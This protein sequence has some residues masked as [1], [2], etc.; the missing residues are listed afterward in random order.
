MRLLLKYLLG[1]FGFISLLLYFFLNSNFSNHYLS[2]Y[3]SEKSKNK[4]TVVSWRIK[5]YPKLN[6]KVKI[7]GTADLLLEGRADLDTLD[8]NYTLTGDSFSYGKTFLDASIDFRGN[9]HGTYNVLMLEGEGNVSNHQE[10]LLGKLTLK[11]ASFD[12]SKEAFLG[13]YLLD[14]QE[15]AHLEPYLH[16][17]YK[18]ALLTTGIVEYRDKNVTLRGETDSFK[19]HLYY[20]YQ[21][22]SIDLT[23]KGVSL[24]K[25][26]EQ[27]RYKALVEA[28]VFGTVR[29]DPIQK[30]AHIDTQL[31]GAHFQKN[32]ITDAIQKQTGIN[33]LSHRY[34][35]SSLKGVYQES[36]LS[37]T[38]K[39]D[40]GQEHLYLK[41]TTIEGQS[42]KLNAKFELKM[43]GQELYGRL[44]GTI[45]KP[46]VSLDISKSLKYQVDRHLGKFL[47]PTQKE[48]LK[49]SLG[50]M[51]KQLKDINMD[52]VKKKA[53][54]LLKNLF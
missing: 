35:Q 3:L 54:N 24:V 21:P 25:L 47:N 27:Y 42:K 36:K 1:F 52:Q 26:L 13:H 15:L 51:K 7:N 23:L 12:L 19:G 14:I 5:E 31:K 43:Q 44:Y 45:N 50:G 4:I 2:D 46:K 10:K 16:Q 22:S 37:A 33:L 41:E 34:E 39:I 40:D 29:Y 30:I 38:I 9:L 32:K 28:K 6:I 11:D 49:E 18:G 20:H 8:M 17:R 48:E 53:K